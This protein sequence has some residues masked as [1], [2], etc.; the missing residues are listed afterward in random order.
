MSKLR[1]RYLHQIS[2]RRFG[3][4]AFALVAACSTSSPSA[5]GPPFASRTFVIERITHDGADVAIVAGSHPT[6]SFSATSM[7]IDTGCN[8]IG[9]NYTLSNSTLSLSDAGGTTKGCTEALVDQE[10]LLSAIV[11]GSTTVERAGDG[12]TIR[13]GAISIAAR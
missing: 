4:A 12:L 7:T 3:F 1:V 9:G 10:R 8:T 2:I 5:S 6:I 11:T 13:T